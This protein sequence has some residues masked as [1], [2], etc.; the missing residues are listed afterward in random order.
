[1]MRSILIFLTTILSA[2]SLAACAEGDKA[3]S[4]DKRERVQ[5]VDALLREVGKSELRYSP[6]TASRL[7]V[8]SNNA[9][10]SSYSSMLDD[11]SQ[12]A[13]ERKRLD[14]IEASTELD[15]IDI[16]GLPEPSRTNFL[17]TQSALRNVIDIAR[18][19]HG[20]VSFGYSRPYAV[21]QLSGAYIDLPDLL[22]NRQNVRNEAEAVAFIDRLVLMADAID[23]ER[24][25]LVAEFDAGI[26]PPRFI[27]ERMADLSS[28][29]S[30]VDENGTHEIFGAF[31]SYVEN[32]AD[33][34][35]RNRQ[36]ILTEAD[37]V[38]KTEILPAYARFENSLTQ[39]AD[40]AREAPGIWAISQG[41]AYYVAALEFYTGQD[42]LE[43]AKL[44][45]D[46]LAIVQDI[47]HDLDIA[48]Q[49]AGYLDGSISERLAQI[50]AVPGQIFA[51]DREGRQAL[52]DRLHDHLDQ[53]ETFLPQI[54]SRRPGTDI[55][56][57]PVPDILSNNAPGGYYSPASA[58]G[59]SP[60]TFFINLRDTAEWPAYSLPTLL[61]HE[62]LPGHHLESA[63]IAEERGLSITRQLIWIPVYGEGWALYAEDLANE[64]DAYAD[65]P[66]GKVGY[67]Q[68]ILFRAARLVADT[69]LHHQRWSRERAVNYLV[70][71]T[72]QSR[73]AMETEVDRYTVWPGQA[74]SYMIGRQFIWSQRQRA[75]KA[76]GDDF[77]LPEFH[78][79][80][81]QN[82]PRPL[83]LVKADVDKWLAEKQAN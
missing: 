28:Q 83:N 31:R 10:Y 32:V 39:L 36:L 69:G 82:G 26:A 66:L 3:F 61:Y 18:F 17:V 15:Q 35:P 8:D 60:A 52:L 19:G 1:M 71:A 67:L 81:L 43:P 11:R 57:A 80:I 45:E 68:S 4:N 48:L 54:I 24:R 41:D 44:H 34:T 77:N 13:F 64:F 65:D 50:H 74:V 9:G 76:L 7:G 63:L 55:R 12:A 47:T 29:L 73:T 51:N 59:T 33:L 14:R 37:R 78:K 56:I 30:S 79:V 2:L 25:R 70:D 49:E 16:S 46:G 38:L 40:K 42:G 5:H 27:F 53:A 58:D 75:Q 6:E 22:L 21:D 72:G 62:A 20:Q 23:D